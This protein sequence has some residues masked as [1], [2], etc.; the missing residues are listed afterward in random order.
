MFSYSDDV[1]TR[2]V[3]AGRFQFQYCE[4]LRQHGMVRSTSLPRLPGAGEYP[5]YWGGGTNDEGS[6]L[7]MRSIPMV[8]YTLNYVIN[9]IL[10]NDCGDVVLL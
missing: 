5:W 3:P 6:F 7:R 9:L 2:D 10:I 4:H 1:A 8:Y